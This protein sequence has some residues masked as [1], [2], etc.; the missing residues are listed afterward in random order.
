MENVEQ[1]CVDPFSLSSTRPIICKGLDVLVTVL[2]LCDVVGELW[3]DG[4]FLTEKINPKD[5]DVVL[6][7]DGALYNSGAAS[8]EMRLTG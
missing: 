3:V 1:V 4:S 5:V 8:N 7:V 2:E 6:R